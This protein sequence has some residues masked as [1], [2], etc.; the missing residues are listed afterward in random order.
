MPH[1]HRHPYAVSQV[2]IEKMAY[3]D[4]TLSE[5]QGELEELQPVLL[6]KQLEV[7]AHYIF[8]IVGINTFPIS[9]FKTHL[10]SLLSHF[11]CNYFNHSPIIEAKNDNTTIL[12][13]IYRLTPLP[14][15]QKRN[16]SN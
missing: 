7:D 4:A 12:R 15:K 2:G 14:R 13:T 5:V 6:A 11:W 10:V 1:T 16:Y 3:V 8:R 9:E